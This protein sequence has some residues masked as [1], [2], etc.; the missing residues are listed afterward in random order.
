[1]RRALA[2]SGTLV[3]GA[4]ALLASHPVWGYPEFSRQTKAAC[5]ACHASI[6]GGA[7][8]TAVGKAFKADHKAAVPTTAKQVEY[9]GVNKCKMCHMK[10][11]K[12]WQ[13][14]A[15]ASAWQTLA[16]ADEKK[17]AEMAALLKI[18]A[19][20]PA[21]KADACVQCH[22]TGFG[23]A[24]GYPAADSTK[25]AAL[26]NITCESCHGPGAKHVA[27][28]MADKKKTMTKNL[29]EAACR[30]CHTPQISPNFKF[31]EFKKKGV[32]QVA[33]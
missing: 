13:T 31:E 1:M 33:G 16:N 32:H 12:A 6:A 24:G 11:H 27:A 18:E 8:L 5:E 29:T 22:V 17:T 2:V 26:Q 23:L 7:E 19:S 28:T 25:N 30:Q 20:H 4:W 15:H 14:T 21:T 10:Q 3:L 9:V